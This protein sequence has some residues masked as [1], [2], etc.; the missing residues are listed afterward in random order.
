MALKLIA[1]YSKRLGLPE[2]SSHQFSVSIEKELTGAEDIAAESEKLYQQ[3]QT[4]VDE[5]IQHTGFVPKKGYGATN[6]NSANG[7]QNGRNGHHNNNGHS[8]LGRW[9][10]SDRQHE[11]ILK[12]IDDNQLDKKE[13][14]AHANEKFGGKGVKQLDKEE[15][16]ELIKYLIE[17]AGPKPRGRKPAR[18]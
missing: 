18:A 13:I 1:S 8:F 4:S 11:L 5:Q 12:L 17:L 9:Q 7:H 3:L 10:C 2:Y 15:A 14:E 6:G 16:S